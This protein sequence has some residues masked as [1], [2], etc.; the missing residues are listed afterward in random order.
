MFGLLV[1]EM[2]G[3]GWQ[4]DA[5]LKKTWLYSSL[6]ACG[7]QK[8]ESSDSKAVPCIKAEQAPENRFMS[9][10]Q[11][12]FQLVSLLFKPRYDLPLLHP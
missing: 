2:S 12:C 4:W 1:G 6:H 9:W 10:R 5:L 3:L 11:T 7:V 8:K